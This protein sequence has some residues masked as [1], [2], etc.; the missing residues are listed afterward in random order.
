[1]LRP[2]AALLLDADGTLVDS[3]APT[4]AAW[5][6]WAQEHGLDAE[7]V[8]ATCHGVPSR[9]HVADWAPELDADAEARAI[10]A[11]QVDSGAPVAAFPGAAELLQAL[12]AE[13]VAVVTSGTPALVRRRFA[14][15]GFA[16]P[17]A[18][19]TA[20]DTERG[21]PDPEPYLAAARLVGAQPHDCLVVEDAPAGIVS[22]VAAGC[23]VA[24][25][26]QTHDAHELGAADAVFAD[27]PA[28]LA[29]VR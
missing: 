10:E 27:L 9:R 19:V 21:K 26:A 2:F 6:A 29:A 18:L 20:D 11:A 16:L 3:R 22:A 4:E 24:A 23:Q 14:D 8:A 12:P 17:A 5:R 28:L 13:R 1:M 15:A 25:V 7:R